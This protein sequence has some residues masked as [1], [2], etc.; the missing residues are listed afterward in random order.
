MSESNEI[1]DATQSLADAT[2]TVAF[3]LKPM[4]ETVLYQ[5]K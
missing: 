3:A 5:P 4:I 2:S 1:L